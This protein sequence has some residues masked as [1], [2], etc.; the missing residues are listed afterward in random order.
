[1][2][3]CGGALLALGAVGAGLTAAQGRASG[4]TAG[5]ERFTTRIVT[6][7]LD[8]PWELTWGPDDQLWSSR[9]RRGRRVLRINPVDGSADVAVTIPESHQS[10]AQDGLLGL[11]LH[12][13]LLRGTGSDYV[14]VAYAYDADPDP[15]QLLRRMKIV[16]YTYARGSRRLT[17]PKNLITGMP[18]SNDHDSGR[19][20][21]GPMASS[22]TR[23]VTRGT[24]SSTT[25]APR[26]AR[27]TCLPPSRSPT[28]TGRP[29]R[30]RSC[31]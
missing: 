16:R 7:G 22:T 25:T 2:V 14:Y 11:A 4:Q 17:R 26:S 23:S 24:T 10:V 30:A 9:K 19:L 21:L 5:P 13:G 27:R 31:G 18:A 20:V 8:S 3:V 15:D 6:S 12:S 28:V 29:T 1:M